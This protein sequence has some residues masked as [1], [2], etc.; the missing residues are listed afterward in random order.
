MRQKDEPP[1]FVS[2]MADR[3]DLAKPMIP[4][5]EQLPSFQSP[6]RNR[7]ENVEAWRRR[8]AMPAATSNAP[9]E[10]RPEQKPHWEPP[11]TAYVG[12]PFQATSV[13]EQRCLM[14]EQD[15]A[16]AADLQARENR[17]HQCHPLSPPPQGVPRPTRDQ[18]PEWP[19]Q[20]LHPSMPSRVQDIHQHSMLEET[21]QQLVHMN[22]NFCT[23]IEQQQEQFNCLLRE[24]KHSDKPRAPSIAGQDKQTGL[25]FWLDAIPHFD[26]KKR[27]DFFEWISKIEDAARQAA[28]ST[29]DCHWTEYRIATLKARGSVF[30]H[31]KAKSDMTPWTKLKEGL[32]MEFSSL[33]T[34]IDAINAL[35]ERTQGPHETLDEYTQEFFR[36]NYTIH[37]TL[38]SLTHN[39]HI[40]NKY[41]RGLHEPELLRKCAKQQGSFD[42]LHDVA[43]YAKLQSQKLRMQ[44]MTVSHTP[45]QDSIMPLQ[46]TSKLP[47]PNRNHGV[48]NQNPS[49][50]FA[51]TPVP[52]VT[53]FTFYRMAPEDWTE[54]MIRSAAARWIDWKCH[55]CKEFRHAKY[56]CDAPAVRKW[57]EAF[58]LELCPSLAQE[59]SKAQAS[60]NSFHATHTHITQVNPSLVSPECFNQQMNQVVRAMNPKPKSPSK[61]SSS[62]APPCA[63]QTTIN[64]PR[65]PPV[66]GGPPKSKGP[67]LVTIKDKPT[68]IPS[69]GPTTRSQAQRNL[70]A[71]FNAF[72]HALELEETGPDEKKDLAEEQVAALSEAEETNDEVQYDPEL[73]EDDISEGAPSETGEVANLSPARVSPETD[74]EAINHCLFPIRIHGHATRAL[75]DTGATH[76]IISKALYD[77][78]SEPPE[79]MP[80][81]CSL[82]VGNGETLTLAGEVML[83]FT[84]GPQH[85]SAWFLVSPHLIHL[86]ILGTDFQRIGAVCL[87]YKKGKAHLVFLK[88]PKHTPTLAALTVGEP[89]IVCCLHLKET[90][91]FP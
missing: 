24:G 32:Q 70:T 15:A 25:R 31:L 16:L 43:T 52:R 29:S 18:P 10:Y 36:L 80:T 46:E 5:V 53:P 48:N 74:L 41:I 91:R 85:F 38:P 7:Q 6:S 22:Q 62:K 1:M 81:R 86:V 84:L 8:H 40:F 35:E 42:N 23:T 37:G 19:A 39:K 67:R 51:T 87:V 83:G 20:P 79:L 75:Y 45:T 12:M 71:Q 88:Q 73:A 9:G 66:K 47:T 26:R 61:S 27:E 17:S 76:S 65:Q 69:S 68:V 90:A 56:I 14:E 58:Q 44:D 60:Q 82:Q 77:I 2:S 33:P 30:T 64:T 63:I 89:K 28:N 54:D 49:T 72:L 57:L 55:A 78:L 21:V 50:G 13:A 59:R 34:M 3:R 4:A 11:R